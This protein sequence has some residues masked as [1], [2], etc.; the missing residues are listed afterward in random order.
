MPESS[1]LRIRAYPVGDQE[2]SQAAGM[3]LIEDFGD[4]AQEMFYRAAAGQMELDAVF[5]VWSKYSCGFPMIIFQQ[6]TQAFF[7]AN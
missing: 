2:V 7:T 3:Y 6:P 1:G 4:L 5:V